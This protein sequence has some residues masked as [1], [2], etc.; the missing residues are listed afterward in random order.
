MSGDD[1][2]GVECG[3]LVEGGD[4]IGPD[5]DGRRADVHVAVVVGDV[6][7]ADQVQVW[8]VQRG[9]FHGVGVASFNH[10]GGAPLELEAVRTGWFSQRDRVSDLAGEPR[11]VVV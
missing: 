11:A 1:G 10:L 6:A 7:G 8:H 2:G 4:P 5:V 3:Q 9:G